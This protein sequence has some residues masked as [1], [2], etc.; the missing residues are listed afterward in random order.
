MNVIDIPV[1]DFGVYILRIEE[2]VVY[3]GYSRSNI[4]GRIGEAYRRFH[5]TSIKI[6]PCDTSREASKLE[7]QLI[8]DYR[9]AG[10]LNGYDRSIDRKD[11]R[12]F[13]K[14]SEERDIFLIYNANILTQQEIADELEVSQMTISRIVTRQYR[15]SI[16]NRLQLGMTSGDPSFVV[17]KPRLVY[18]NPSVDHGNLTFV[19][20]K[21]INYKGHFLR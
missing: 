13:F 4:Y 19:L 1:V 7:R 15:R 5:P 9:P 14:E 11:S 18:G 2:E 20:F 10:N 12:R 6:I 8:E 3:I 16:G 17:I 21:L